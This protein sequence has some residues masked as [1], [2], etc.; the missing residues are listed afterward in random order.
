MTGPVIVDTNIVVAGL[1]TSRDDAP[2][3]W[4]LDGMLGASF[5]F[6]V[7]EALLAEYRDVLDRPRLCRAHGLAPRERE[8]LLTRVACNAIVLE[9]HPAAPAPDPGDQHLWELLAAREDLR[10]VTGDL[11]LLSAEGTSGRVWSA[12]RFVAEARGGRRGYPVQEQTAQ[13]A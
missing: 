3:A 5:P 4:I 13:Y 7:S 1:L 6:V 11:E 8:I 12:E 10:L 2:V 9:P